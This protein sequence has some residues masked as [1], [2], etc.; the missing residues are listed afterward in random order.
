MVSL[1][2]E[3]F[4]PKQGCRQGR[5]LIEQ[6]T[7]YTVLRSRD[8]SETGV[9]TYGSW[10]WV[11]PR[12]VR[13]LSST[14]QAIERKLTDRIVPKGGDVVGETGSSLSIVNDFHLGPRGRTS[15][16]LRG[17]SVVLDSSPSHLGVF[18][19]PT[20]VLCLRF[21]GSRGVL[22][23]RGGSESLFSG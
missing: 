14:Y 11:G 13:T 15:T 21:R 23:V 4:S 5:G 3:W 6:L 1:D 18:F 16:P 22:R 7:L 8:S 2:W 19:Y 17:R 10:V 9:P 12:T 20:N